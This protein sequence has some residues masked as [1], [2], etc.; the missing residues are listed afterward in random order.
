MLINAVLTAWCPSMEDCTANTFVDGF[1]K[2]GCNAKNESELKCHRWAIVV[3]VEL[4]M[5]AAL[6]SVAFWTWTCNCSFYES[7]FLATY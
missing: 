1:Q 7:E 2:Q 6:K 4:K 5:L 3:V